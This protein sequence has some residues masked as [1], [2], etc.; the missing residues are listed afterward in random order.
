M[1][2]MNRRQ[3][4][5]TTS[6]ATAAVMARSASPLS[7]ADPAASTIQLSAF[8][9]PFRHLNFEATADLVAQVGWEGIELPVRARSSHLDPEK[10]EDELPRMVDALAARGKKVFLIATDVNQVDALGERVLRTAAKVGIERYRLGTMYYDLDRPIPDQLAEFKSR[11]TDLVALNKELGLQGGIQNHSGARYVGA[12][13]WDVHRLI[14]DFDPQQLGI[15]YD[16]GH[17]TLEG[18]YAWNLNWRLIRDHLVA[19]YVKDFYWEQK[20]SGWEAKW[21]PLGEGMVVPQF[22]KDLLGS[23]YTG[24]INQHHEY[25]HGEGDV[26]IENCKKDL[27]QLKQWL[28]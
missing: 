8:S 18:G 11:L 22:F 20:D 25:D 15:C 26:L 6:L 7:A 23:G 2:S 24:I 10:V 9:K 14:R 28:G 17:S 21:C 27:E 5:Q 1:D 13:I 12:P 16:I 3:F 19:L 4:I